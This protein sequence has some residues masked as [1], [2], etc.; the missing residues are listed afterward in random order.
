[1]S[2]FRSPRGGSRGPG[3]A[4][5]AGC[6]LGARLGAGLASATLRQRHGRRPARLTAKVVELTEVLPRCRGP[7]LQLHHPVVEVL[8]SG[9]S[10]ESQDPGLSI[11]CVAHATLPIVSI[12]LVLDRTLSVDYTGDMKKSGRKRVS[13]AEQESRIVAYCLVYGATRRANGLPPYP[14]GSTDPEQ[15][16]AWQRIASV[17]RRQKRHREGLCERCLSRVEAPDDSIFCESCRAKNAARAGRYD[18]TLEVRQALYVLQHGYCPLCQRKI[19]VW[20]HADHDHRTGQT[21]GLVCGP[22]NAALRFIDL[23]GRGGLARLTA[24]LSEPPALPRR[25]SPP[26]GAASGHPE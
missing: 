24:Y 12:L 5:R 26:A 4:R 18:T 10:L 1:V 22:C 9:E 13:D 2:R 8:E 3:V 20:D 7:G 19:R 25:L 17:A 14:T 6:P 11:Y 23:L 15:N 21:R 16:R